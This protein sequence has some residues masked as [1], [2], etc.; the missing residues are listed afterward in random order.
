MNFLLQFV[1]GALYHRH[2]ECYMEYL[3]LRNKI[4]V[5]IFMIYF[6]V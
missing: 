5:R 2:T 1:R 3:G 4:R 6:N